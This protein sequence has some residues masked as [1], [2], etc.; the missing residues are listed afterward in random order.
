MTENGWP[1]ER[2][3]IIDLWIRYRN[4]AALVEMYE[5][6]KGLYPKEFVAYSGGEIIARAR[7]VVPLREIVERE[8][9][10][11][12]RVG[13]IYVDPELTRKQVSHGIFS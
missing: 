9:Y 11:W 6:L 1:A 3:S 2:L 8:G 5:E 10:S 12:K 13:I 7:D 4:D